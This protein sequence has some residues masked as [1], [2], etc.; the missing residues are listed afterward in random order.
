M[1]VGRALFKTYLAPGSKV[2]DLYSFALGIY[3]MAGLGTVIHWITEC[4]ATYK[5]NEYHNEIMTY[6]KE[7]AKMV[8]KKKKCI[9]K[10]FSNIL[11]YLDCKVYILFYCV[12]CSH[13]TSFR[14]RS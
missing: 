13:T 10:G 1:L 3:I 14:N 2:N 11:F 5:A 9:R 8:K 12:W 7:K 6:M 4:Y